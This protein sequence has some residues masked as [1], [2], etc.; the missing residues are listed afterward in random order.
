M[1]AF[2]A[3]SLA[4]LSR[5]TIAI[6]DPATVPASADVNA[7]AIEREGQAIKIRR[8]NELFAAARAVGASPISRRIH[9]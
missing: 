2:P 3:L 7:Q 4:T 6:A 8:V 9:L 1:E 5:T